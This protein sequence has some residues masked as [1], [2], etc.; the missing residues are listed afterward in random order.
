MNKGTK[1][2]FMWSDSK[3]TGI[4]IAP[5]DHGW[6]LVAVKPEVDKEKNVCKVVYLPARE[7]AIIN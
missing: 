7:C 5:E 6:V 2:E 3:R 1:V 4:V